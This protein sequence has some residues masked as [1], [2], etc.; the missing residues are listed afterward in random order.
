MDEVIKLLGAAKNVVILP[1][2]NA[3]GDAVGSCAAMAELMDALGRKSI[4]YAEEKPEQRLAFISERVRVYD[5]SDEEEYDTCIVLDCGDKERLGKRAVFAERAER[6][7]C[8][9]HHKTNT[10]FG[11]AC[12]VDASASATGE[13]MAE[14]YDRMGIEPTKRAA[15]CM[16][17]A[18][19]SDSGCFAYSNTSPKTMRVAAGLM[20]T[21][22]DHAEAA[23]LLFDSE[24]LETELLKAEL[25]GHI[26]SYYG[27]RLRAVT[28]TDAMA[29]K[30]GLDMEDVS[31]IVNIPRRICG[32]EIAVSVKESGGKIRVSLR[33]NGSADVS[34]AAVKFG[35]GGHAKAAGCTVNAGSVDEALEMVVKECGEL[36]S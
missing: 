22:I 23:R 29:E 13:I 27:G 4:I 11:D 30:Y 6:I 19:C 34:A 10:G 15:L 8:I 28:A 20:E 5:G 18:I 1:H 17:A 24:P 9:D 36:L 35:G 3:D 31:D 32:T 14:L 7:V 12:Y 16:Y 25:T 33:S 26:R 21:G 2:I